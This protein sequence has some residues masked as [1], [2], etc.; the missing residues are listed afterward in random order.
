MSG[1][2]K[3]MKQKTSASPKHTAL[4]MWR[5]F[6]ST[7]FATLAII[8]ILGFMLVKW[9]HDYLL[10]TEQFTKIASELPQKPQVTAALSKFTTQKLFEAIDVQTLVGDA[11]PEKAKFLAAPLT[12]Q[13][14]VT[15]TDLA[16]N[17]IKSQ[18]FDTAW[19]FIVSGAH[20]NFLKIVNASPLDVS[21]DQISKVGLQLGDVVRN[22][23]AQLGREEIGVAVDR[24]IGTATEVTFDLRAQLKLVRQTVAAV[25]YLY[26][27]LP[28]LALTLALL[29]IWLSHYMSRAIL[30]MSIAGILVV[31]LVLV[32]LKAA[33]SEA[34]M[35]LQDPTYQAAI[36]VSWDVIVQ[37]LVQMLVFAAIALTVIMILSLLLGPYKWAKQLR[38]AAHLEKIGHTRFGE[39]FELSRKFVEKYY[40]AG[41][42][43]AA[44]VTIA[45]LLV[46][47]QITWVSVLQATLAWLSFCLLLAIYIKRP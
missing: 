30:A 45:A 46:A 11:L 23:A 41:C 5:I 15:A 6:G 33:K 17:I 42:G 1:L 40:L 24:T 47:Q 21:N 22:V 29:A 28:L 14:Q 34:V 2:F 31:G 19:T 9:T 32:A 43:C 7:V 16:N 20:E 35:Q 13:L 12:A 37:G 25:N 36:A 26:A 27:I 39:W 3:N 4:D 38:T 8:S 44:V 18:Q 10:N